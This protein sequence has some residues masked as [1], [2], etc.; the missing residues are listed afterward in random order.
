MHLSAE[1]EGISGIRGSG[2]QKR[3][4]LG[5]AGTTGKEDYPGNGEVSGGQLPQ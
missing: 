4:G 5:P 3:G 1:P 2:F